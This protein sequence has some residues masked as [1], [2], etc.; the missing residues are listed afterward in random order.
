MFAFAV[1]NRLLNDLL[2]VS[3]CGN[4][5]YTTCSPRVNTADKDF[6]CGFLSTWPSPF[7]GMGHEHCMHQ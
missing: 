7:C 1:S 2:V 6:G 5:H 4:E 3:F